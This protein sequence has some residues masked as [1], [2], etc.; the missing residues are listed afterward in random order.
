MRLSNN[1]VWKGAQSFIVT[2]DI[3]AEWLR[4]STN[5]LAQYQALAATAP[6]ISNLI[7]GAIATQA[8]FVIESPYCNAFQPPNP[9]GL[10]PTQNRQGDTVHPIYEPSMVFEC[11]YELDSLA[12][13]LSLSNQYYANTNSTSFLNNR[14]FMALRALTDVL[15]A[16]SRPTFT[17]QYNF[18]GNQ[19]TF[20]RWTNAGTETLPLNGLGN[21]MANHTGLVRSAFRP[22]DDAAVFPF[23]I[24]ANAMMSVEL[25]RAAQVLLA[26]ANTLQSTDPEAYAKDIDALRTFAEYLSQKSARIR[27][28]ILDHG[29]TIHPKFGKVFVYETDGYGSHLLMDDANIPSLLSLPLLGFISS[30]SNSPTNANDE[31]AQIYK[32]TRRMLLDPPSNPYYLVGPALHGIGSPHTGLLSTWPISLLVQAMTS[33]FPAEILDCLSRVKRVSIFG[34]I[35]ES[36]DVRIGPDPRT[37]QGMTRPWFAWANSVFAQAVLKFAAERPELLFEQLQAGERYVVGKG[38]VGS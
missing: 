18:F 25:G 30:T 10:A 5:Q 34:L 33:A 15:E 7:K 20:S 13:F 16:Q 31:T 2:G 3:N 36:V 11:K 38:W 12:A 27:T 17:D 21:P 28:G 32:N 14:W 23:L 19:Y 8:E 4:D 35:N 1:A 6:D 29:T 37:G 9:S 26:H 24:P 22:S